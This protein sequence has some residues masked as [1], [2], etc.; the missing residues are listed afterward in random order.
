MGKRF[1]IVTVLLA[2]VPLSGCKKSEGTKIENFFGAPPEVSEV[3]LT[4]ERKDVFCAPSVDDIEEQCFW[5]CV[6]TGFTY[7]TSIDLVTASARV[8]DAT[9]PT[10]QYPSD[11]LVVVVRFKDPPPDANTGQQIYLK[12]LE[13]YDEGPNVEGWIGTIPIQSGD[14]VAGDGIFTRKFYFGS[15]TDETAGDCLEQTDF[16]NLSCTFST[17]STVL[18]IAPS[19]SVDFSF[20]IQAIDRNGNIDTSTE[21]PLPIQGTFRDEESTG[22]EDCGGVIPGSDPVACYPP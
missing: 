13:M 22:W 4:K 1:W 16:A 21:F 10:E 6:W 8:V 11:I 14:L 3:S 5:T 7:A 2:L 20:Y 15:Y 9:E 18:T 12:S 17:Y 19:E